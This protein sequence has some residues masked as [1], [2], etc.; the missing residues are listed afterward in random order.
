MTPNVILG[1]ILIGYVLGAL[2]LKEDKSCYVNTFVALMIRSIIY[3]PR[4]SFSD[5]L[6]TP[7]NI[8]NVA[9][10]LCVIAAVNVITNKNK[11]R[12]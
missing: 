9:I 11:T 1:S 10:I 4:A 8:W 5:W 2:R 7:F 3:I 12:A 6:A